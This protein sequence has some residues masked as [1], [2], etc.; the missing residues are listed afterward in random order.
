METLGYLYHCSLCELDEQQD[1]EL[2]QFSSTSITNT[3]ALI[4]A[5]SV[6]SA[7]FLT[8]H[9]AVEARHL[10]Y[11]PCYRPYR[12]PYESVSYPPYLS[13]GSRGSE[14]RE[15]QIQLRNWGYPLEPNNQLI[16]DGVFGPQTDK[17]VRQFQKDSGLTVDGIVG[18]RTW[19]ALFTPRQR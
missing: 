4:L 17:A 10:A 5:S 8:G 15:I 1:F 9:A 18:W 13:Q 2:P 19:D 7:S 11:R 14:V 12:Y 6:A 3:M 16:V